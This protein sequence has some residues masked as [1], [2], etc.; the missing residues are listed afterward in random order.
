MRRKTEV[1]SDT[2][3]VFL[4]STIIDTSSAADP[5]AGDDR[6]KPH[7]FEMV[8]PDRSDPHCEHVPLRA[9]SR[10]W[11][12]FRPKPLSFVCNIVHT[13]RTVHTERHKNHRPVLVVL[14]W[15]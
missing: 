6:Q 2:L 10:S 12:G 3:C 4:S 15:G 11:P 9:D 14:E 13:A 5:T 7:A 1:V 8:A